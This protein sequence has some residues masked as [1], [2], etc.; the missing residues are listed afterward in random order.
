VTEQQMDSLIQDGLRRL[1]TAFGEG[2]SYMVSELFSL[3]GEQADLDERGKAV[4]PATPGAVPRRV[5]GKLQSHVG[6]ERTG[7]AEWVFGI[8]AGVGYSRRLEFDMNHPFFGLL[9][10]DR[11]SQLTSLVASTVRGS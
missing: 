1:D 4:H 5:S 2:A 7:P 6:F 11:L 8:R 3:I 9:I 10:Q